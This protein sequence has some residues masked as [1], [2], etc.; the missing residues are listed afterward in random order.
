MFLQTL[1]EVHLSLELFLLW[2]FPEEETA[3]CPSGA[4]AL[5]R[6]ALAFQS[7]LHIPT[8][9][10][11]AFIRQTT[12]ENRWKTPE[13]LLG[14]LLLFH[15]DAAENILLGQ[16]LSSKQLFKADFKKKEK[17]KKPHQKN[18]SLKRLDHHFPLMIF[19]KF[20]LL[21]SQNFS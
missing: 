14:A 17:T 18:P 19:K 9:P 1:N 4:L 7:S 10:V 8:H 12:C 5:P 3:T 2:P 15:G 11:A 20:I 13:S 6:T 16:V 21:P